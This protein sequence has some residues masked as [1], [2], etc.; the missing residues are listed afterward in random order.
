MV[1]SPGTAA[2]SVHPTLSA[3][4]PTHESQIDGAFGE[5]AN[6]VRPILLQT[7]KAGR[8]FVGVGEKRAEHE[9]RD[10]TGP[11]ISRPGQRLKQH[12]SSYRVCLDEV[13]GTPTLETE[14]PSI[15]SSHTG[16]CTRTYVRRQGA[17]VGPSH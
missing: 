17:S 5:L 15:R 16:Y 8:Q 11:F 2:R 4:F 7:F 12:A 14:F 10:V 1:P 9:R 3:N 6:L 13:V